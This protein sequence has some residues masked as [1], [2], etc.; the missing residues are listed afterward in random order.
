M[1]K[2]S[3]PNKIVTQQEQI[4]AERYQVVNS[5]AGGMGI[6]YLC[7]DN[8]DNGAPIALKTFQSKFLPD[9]DTRE[10]FLREAI[11]W[12][13]LGWH[14]NIVQAF[15]AEYIKS[16]HEIYLTMELIPTAPGKQNPSLRSWITPNSSMP[17][18]KA[19]MICLDIARGMKFATQK[20]PGLV[21]RDLKPE[22]ILIGLDGTARITDFGLVKISNLNTYSEKENQM[23]TNEG[24][25]TP[26]YMSPEQWLEQPTSASTDI[27]SFGCIAY[28]LI[29]GRLAVQ[30]KTSDVLAQNHIHGLAFQK[31][32]ELNIH[33]AFKGFIAKCVHPD[34]E[35][36]FQT[37]ESL[38]NDLVGLMTEILNIKI[39]KENIAI[40]V[41]RAGQM[42]KGESLLALGNSYLDIGKPNTAIE[43]FEQAIL[44]GEAQAYSELIAI[45][46]GNIGISKFN[47]GEFQ[48]A[49]SYYQQAIEIGIRINLI[50]IVAM[51]FGNAG[52]AYFQ[53]GNFKQALENFEKIIQ[54]AHETQNTYQEFFWKQNK[55]NVYSVIGNNE[56][57]LNLYQEVYKFSESQNDL[58]GISHALTNIGVALERLG[59]LPDAKIS[60][61]K[62][63]QTS[64]QLGDQKNILTSLL[65]ISHILAWQRKIEEAIKY[66][67]MGFSI[68]ENISDKNAMASALGDLGVCYTSNGQYNEA[69][70]SLNR[71]I[72]LSKEI[73]N[74]QIL[75]RA[76]WTLGLLNETKREFPNAIRNQ[77]E[78]VVLF[79]EL[80]LPE[81]KQASDHLLELRKLLGL[82]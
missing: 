73:N 58:Y 31:A 82:V 17:L 37:W 18:S 55:A 61:E 46:K 23:E 42:R 22:N 40:D 70:S 71:A 35:K 56:Q 76:Y 48:D 41:S 21:H 54:F 67:R 62:A 44:I 9:L 63:L 57:A 47:L 24:V 52:N 79:N 49:L 29:T 32:S 51:N 1:S 75:A 16:S 72:N 5:I 38:E 81:Y 65:G 13:E 14:P 33:A 20:I 3:T 50:E 59:K 78:A 8:A 60:F 26:I 28:E 39:N 12:I 66:A 15:H 69:L 77:R 74:R 36:R 64:Q 2:K 4:I 7:K 11:I 25:G 6:V 68:A 80:G 53:I 30:G 34:P 45:C 27:Y 43:Y 19:M 10:K